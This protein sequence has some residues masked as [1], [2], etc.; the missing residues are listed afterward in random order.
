MTIRITWS[1]EELEVEFDKKE[2][3]VGRVIW[4]KKR[5]GAK[6]INITDLLINNDD[7]MGEIFN[8]CMEKIAEEA[9][10]AEPAEKGDR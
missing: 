6:Y 8:L 4:H 5:D 9:D 1:G 10:N 7:I 3:E 2:L